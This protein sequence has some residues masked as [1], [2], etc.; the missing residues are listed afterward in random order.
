ML[1]HLYW[2]SS[3]KLNYVCHWGAIPKPICPSPIF[4]FTPYHPCKQPL[5]SLLPPSYHLFPCVLVKPVGS[6]T[7][8]LSSG[9]LFDIFFYYLLEQSLSNS[10]SPASYCVTKKL[11]VLDSYLSPLYFYISWWTVWNLYGVVPPAPLHFYFPFSLWVT[12]P[13]D[14]LWSLQAPLLLLLSAR[15]VLFHSAWH[16]GAFAFYFLLISLAQH[17]VSVQLLLDLLSLASFR[18]PLKSVSNLVLVEPS[19]KVDPVKTG[20]EL[21][22]L[23]KPSHS[24]LHALKT[25]WHV[26]VSYKFCHQRISAPCRFINYWKLLPPQIY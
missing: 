26:Q 20:V 15:R 2:H 12:V 16:Y 3:L 4:I 9:I 13:H 23:L 1:W 10:I 24:R 7:Y 11:Q 21:W 6:C 19:R 14:L 18:F 17:D 25:F 8:L 22:Q 5:S